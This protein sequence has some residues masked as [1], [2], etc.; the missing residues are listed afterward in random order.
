MNKKND[1]LK[2]LRDHEALVAVFLAA[3]RSEG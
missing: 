3:M 2:M 1:L